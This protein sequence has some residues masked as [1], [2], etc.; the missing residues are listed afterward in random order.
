MSVKFLETRGKYQVRWR[1]GGRQKAR[2]FDRKGDADAFDL[3]QRRR[4]Q[5]GG[6][7][8]QVI[9]AKMTLAQFVVDEYWPNYAMRNLTSG[10]R[11]NY[12][13]VWGKHL[14]DRLGG[15]E[16]REIT[17]ALVDDFL[18]QLE[19]AG[20]GRPRQQTALTLL[21]GVLSHAA[22]RDK[23]QVNPVR[24]V[25]K[26]KLERKPTPQPLAP[27]TVETIR[28]IMLEPKTRRVDSSRPG[29]R[30]RRGYE[31]P[32]GTALE[33]TRNAL[34][35]SI[36]AYA[37][38]RPIEDRGATWG[39]LRK[40]TLHVFATKTS[41]ER[42]VD[43]LEPLA[44][45]LAEYRILYSREVGI[46]NDDD[47]IIPRPTGGAWTKSD[48]GNW[49]NRVWRPAVI[50]AGVTG[51]LRPYRLRGSF[52]SLLLW[53]GRSITYVA[54]QAGH[55]VATLAR[56]YAGTM[57][58]LEGHDRT[59]AAD[60]IKKARELVADGELTGPGKASAF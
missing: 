16:L 19:K 47:L 15:Y 14:D 7:A 28:A 11:Q 42:F 32:Y 57:R 44:I 46:P 52:V 55:S 21:S 12:L 33:R 2:L 39:D 30:Q 29:Q 8:S 36:L 26:P 4:R 35:V 56:H 17:P 59:P 50:A 53:E 49:R 34:I 45:D 54:D 58:D 18:R 5:L 60:A 9:Q 3:E 23:I 37:G 20:V 27:H 31:A 25:R 1:E 13:D 48:W 22:V 24:Q 6:L 10:T 43:V 38:L 41:R 40:R 51:D